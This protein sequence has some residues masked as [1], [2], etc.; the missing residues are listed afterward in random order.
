MRYLANV[1]SLEYFPERC[2]GCGRCVEVCPHGVF[3][4]EDKRALLA[5]RDSCMECGACAQNCE[6]EAIKVNAGVGCAYAIINSMVK[7]GGAE[8]GCSVSGSNGDS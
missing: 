8:C 7:G 2:V 5:N 6:F 3:R 1:T 4:M